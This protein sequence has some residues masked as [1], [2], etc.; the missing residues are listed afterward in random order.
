[1]IP[2][3]KIDYLNAENKSTSLPSKAENT[4][5]KDS[6]NYELKKIQFFGRLLPI[7]LQNANGPC[8]LIAIGLFQLHSDF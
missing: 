1:V 6:Q 3:R 8:P 2:T 4:N 7:V 5:A